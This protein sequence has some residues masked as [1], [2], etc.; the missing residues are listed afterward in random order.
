M[1]S[2]EDESRKTSTINE[3]IGRDWKVGNGTIVD[4]MKEKVM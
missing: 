1:T 2:I 3:F 4:N